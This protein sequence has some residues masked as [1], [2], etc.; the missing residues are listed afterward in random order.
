MF[1]PTVRGHGLVVIDR[2]EEGECETGIDTILVGIS[3]HD[4]VPVE[5][6]IQIVERLFSLC[7]CHTVDGGFAIRYLAVLI[8]D[9]HTIAP[10]ANRWD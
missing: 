8:H 5:E 7:C 2:P 1:L 9:I 6:V 10:F 3:F 4:V